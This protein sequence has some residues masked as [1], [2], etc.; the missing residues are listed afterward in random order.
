MTNQSRRWLEMIWIKLWTNRCT[1][2]ARAC[3]GIVVSSSSLSC[4]FVCNKQR[5]ALLCNTFEVCVNNNTQEIEMCVCVCVSGENEEMNRRFRTEKE[6]VWVC[7]VLLLPRNEEKPHRNVVVMK[8]WWRLISWWMNSWIQGEEMICK[9]LLSPSLS[10]QGTTREGEQEREQV[11]WKSAVLIQLP[12]CA[13]VVRWCMKRPPPLRRLQ[14]KCV[15]VCV[16][17]ACNN[18]KMPPKVSWATAFTISSLNA[19]SCSKSCNQFFVLPFFVSTHHT[20]THSV[21]LQGA[22]P[23][24]LFQRF[25]IDDLHVLTVDFGLLIYIQVCVNTISVLN[26][27]IDWFCFDPKAGSTFL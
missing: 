5:V 7:R 23:N 27:T 24:F 11:T 17:E 3:S 21:G 1:Q 18:S 4:V 26:R 15:C 6:K 12:L 9:S 25:L 13:R 8:L 19:L 14:L 2:Q 10:L 16:C 22:N 20:H